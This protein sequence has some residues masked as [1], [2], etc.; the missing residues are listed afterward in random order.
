MSFHR[1]AEKNVIQLQEE[2]CRK[3]WSTKNLMPILNITIRGYV[4]SIWTKA[5]DGT[6]Y[7][8]M[9]RID[10]IKIC[11]VIEV[12]VQ[13]QRGRKLN[14]NSLLESLLIAH[15]FELMHQLISSKFNCF[16]FWTTFIYKL[17][18]IFLE[19]TFEISVILQIFLT[20]GFMS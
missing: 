8:K 13:S 11:N 20:I 4:T 18:L 14:L 7:R 16:A 10:L 5:D 9:W 12:Q 17:R 3:T 6:R 1:D 15:H 19:Q 2:N